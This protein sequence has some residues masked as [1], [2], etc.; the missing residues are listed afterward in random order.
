MRES[1]N[2]AEMQMLGCNCVSGVNEVPTFIC[3][4]FAVKL[5]RCQT[6]SALIKTCV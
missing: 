4:V 3:L 5:L 6:I 1:L 2:V